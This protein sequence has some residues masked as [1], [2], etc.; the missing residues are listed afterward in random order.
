MYR[1]CKHA[2]SSLQHPKVLIQPV[3]LCCFLS[4]VF[5]FLFDVCNGGAFFGCVVVVCYLPLLEHIW[6]GKSRDSACSY[7][8]LSLFYAVLQ[9]SLLE[10]RSSQYMYI[11]TIKIPSAPGGLLSGQTGK[12][13]FILKAG[14]LCPGLLCK[15]IFCYK[16][17][18]ALFHFSQSRHNLYTWHLLSDLTKLPVMRHLTQTDTYGLVRSNGFTI[19]SSL[20]TT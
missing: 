13:N 2:L 3:A 1:S 5:L 17:T 18:E 6:P 4:S 7:F 11:I 20:L 10:S 19:L 9:D 14:V 12:P 16:F 8:Q 15:Y